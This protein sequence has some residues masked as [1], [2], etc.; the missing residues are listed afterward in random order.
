MLILL[1]G[2]FSQDQ[3]KVTWYVLIFYQFLV[4]KLVCVCVGGWVWVCMHT[5]GCLCILLCVYLGIIFIETTKAIMTW[6]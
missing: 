3:D 1:Y 2:V 6:T 5:F 4:M